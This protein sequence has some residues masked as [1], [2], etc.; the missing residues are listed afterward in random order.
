M[1]GM[2]DFV[3][4]LDNQPILIFGLG[5]SGLSTAKAFQEA[6][7]EVVVDDDDVKNLDAAKNYKFEILNEADDLTRFA[8]LVLSPGIPLT[9]PEPHDIVKRAKAADIEIICDVELFSRVY[10]D[11]K[12]IGITGTN[13]KS[14]TASLM[15]HALVETGHKALLGGNIGTPVFDLSVDKNT[16]W[17][18]LEI[19]SF[20]IDLCPTFRPDISLILNITPDHIDRHGSMEEYVDVKERLVELGRSSG[21]QIAVICTDDTHTQKIHERAVD[22]KLRDVIEVSA[23]KALAG[24]VFV[25]DAILYDAMDQDDSADA[26]MIGNMRKIVS[27]RGIHN[28]QNAACVYSALKKIGITSEKLWSAIE[29]FPGLRHRQFMVCTINGV[30]YVND[31]KST[32]AASAAVALAC[33]DNVYW[34][35]GGRKKKTGLDG[36]EAFFSHIKHA[37]LIGESSDDF[38]KWFDQYGMDYTRCTTLE[39]ALGD[40]HE[41]AQAQRGQP[42]GAG[43]VLLSPACASFDQYKSFEHRGDDFTK[44]V[45]ALEE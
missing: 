38:A 41:M 31:S 24:G 45:M 44:F 30:G 22:L 7:V 10:S 43:V 9:H 1:S 25:N 21:E 16:E 39:R 12:T 8:F 18:V 5:K 15:H 35:V 14:T 17:V 2:K 28:H 11:M 26:E 6:G 4:H 20:Q 3:G 37:F 34:I 36:L 23:D 29:T 13:G 33:Q 40:A 27:L 32:N 19:S 42:G